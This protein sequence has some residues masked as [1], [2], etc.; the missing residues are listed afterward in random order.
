MLTTC[1]TRR[2]LT[3]S[4]LLVQRLF[5]HLIILVLAATHAYDDEEELEW[6]GCAS[7]PR[8]FCGP[9]WAKVNTQEICNQCWFRIHSK[10]NCSS[11]HFLIWY[12]YVYATCSDI[13]TRASLI[14]FNSINFL[15][16]RELHLEWRVFIGLIA[17]KSIKCSR[18]GKKKRI[19]K[20]K[21]DPPY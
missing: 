2:Q 1:C 18:S 9:C 12:V 14:F 8:W 13:H 5:Y 21:R 20:K 3:I 17:E 7:C 4:R 19:R 6:A 10:L 11:D 15:Q 16:T